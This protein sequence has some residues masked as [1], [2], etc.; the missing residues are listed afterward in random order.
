MSMMLAF[1]V[2]VFAVIP[3]ADEDADL[4]EMVALL[5]RLKTADNRQPTNGVPTP[6]RLKLMEGRHLPSYPTQ[7]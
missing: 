7:V 2:K 4:D 3:A 5:T 1:C 6:R